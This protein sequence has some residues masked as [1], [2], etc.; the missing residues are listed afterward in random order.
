MESTSASSGWENFILIWF[1]FLLVGLLRRFRRRKSF[2]LARAVN[3]LRHNW[4]SV[5]VWVCPL[6]L[7]QIQVLRPIIFNL[8]YLCAREYHRQFGWRAFVDSVLRSCCQMVFRKLIGKMLLWLCW[9]PFLFL[10]PRLTFFIFRLCSR[11]AAL[12]TWFDWANVRFLSTFCHR[13][14][15]GRPTESLLHTFTCNQAHRQPGKKI[16]VSHTRTSIAAKSHT[17]NK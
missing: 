1:L 11:S 9:I 16:K 17:N 8:I 13:T 10:L 15:V 6:C 3:D 4:W 12:A 5:C 2:V 7:T 14:C